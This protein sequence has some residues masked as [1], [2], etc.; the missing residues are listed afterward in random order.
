MP[1]AHQLETC[2]CVFPINSAE[3]LILTVQHSLHFLFVL[4]AHLPLSFTLWE[5]VY[6]CVCRQLDHIRLWMQHVLVDNH[7]SMETALCVE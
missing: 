4:P 7:P 6:S 2:S 3:R 5:T 1:T